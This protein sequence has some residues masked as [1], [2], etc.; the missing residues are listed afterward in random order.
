MKRILALLLI[1]CGW[2][3]HSPPAHASCEVQSGTPTYTNGQFIGA[4]LCDMN[5]NKKVTSTGSGGGSY[6]AAATA[7]EA[8]PTYTEGQTTAPLSLNTQGALRATLETLFAGED[9]GTGGD[10]SLLR[11]SGGAVRGTV[12]NMATGVTTNTT[13]AASILPVREKSI[14]GSVTGT[15]AVTQTQKIYGG[16]TS[17]FTPATDGI[18]LCTLTLSGTTTAVDQCP[19][20]VSNNL[21]YKVVTSGT[22]GTGATGAV[23]AQY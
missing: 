19:V 4:D 8:P 6:T 2:A 20:I 7:T 11:T 12:G 13:S 18:L 15:G 14:Y 5:G 10:T 21:F 3:I 9:L 17:G 22:T 1:L 16:I 23:T